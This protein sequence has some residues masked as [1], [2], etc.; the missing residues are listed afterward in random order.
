M[1]ALSGADVFVI[2]TEWP[3]F[4]D[5]DWAAARYVMRSP[6]VVDGG[7]VAGNEAMKGHAATWYRYATVGTPDRIP[8][9]AGA[10]AG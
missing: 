3:V 4:R 10:P 5:L 2:G 6:V 8:D 9:V 7:R 1:A